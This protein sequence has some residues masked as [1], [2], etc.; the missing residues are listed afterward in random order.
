MARVLI[1]TFGFKYG[2]PP[3][4]YYFDVS[5]AVNPARQQNWSLFSQPEPEMVS[6]VLDQPDVSE[7]LSAVVPLIRA[8]I[9]FDDDARI[10]IGCNAGRHRSVI[11][12]EEIS[13]RLRLEKIEVSL[14]HREADFGL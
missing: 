9:K 3:T 8:I 2:P 5:F 12:A 1:V 7:F 13:R 6:F 11:I 10:G 4:N 14:M